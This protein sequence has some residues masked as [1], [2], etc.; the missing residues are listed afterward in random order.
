MRVFFLSFFSPGHSISLSCSLISVDL[1]R[2]L[3]CWLDTGS[4]N[5]SAVVGRAETKKEKNVFSCVNFLVYRPDRSKKKEQKK[6]KE[7]SLSGERKISIEQY[8]NLYQSGTYV[9]ILVPPLLLAV[10]GL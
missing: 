1:S 5:Y 10:K 2:G 4:G 3:F 9:S 7:K 6:D 8:S